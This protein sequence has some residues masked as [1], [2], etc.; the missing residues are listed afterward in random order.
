MAQ[1][2]QDGLRIT[3]EFNF[4][5]F[6]AKNGKPITIAVIAVAVIGIGLLYRQH[7]SSEQVERAADRLAGATDVASLEQI[8]RDYPG[9][10]TAGNALL[11]VADFYYRNG[12]YPEAASTYERIEKEIPDYPLADSVKL[13][14][15]AILEAQGNLAG[16]RD[17]YQQV[18]NF[19]PNSYVANASRMGLA[20]CLEALGQ[21]KEAR[22]VYEELLAG[23]QNSPW[24]TQAYLQ[25][26]VM[27]RDVPPEKA[28]EP[29][30]KTAGTPS[31]NNLTLPSFPA[32][33]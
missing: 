24:F 17:Q 22:Q 10:T 30:T 4:E 26:V 18:I 11:R 19:S 29:S 13:S 2:A 32:K 1:G 20:R 21:K 15:A 7:Q 25:W 12:K 33:P 14:H 27:N 23:G 9:S 16:A 8:A 28:S 6:W 3:D 5:E 31:Q